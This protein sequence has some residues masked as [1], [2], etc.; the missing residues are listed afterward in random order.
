MIKT[1]LKAFLILLLIGG[2]LFSM[3][4][5][6][7]PHIATRIC[8]VGNIGQGKSVWRDWY[9][10]NIYRCTCWNPLGD[11]QYGKVIS[12][13]QYRKEIP[14]MRSGA[15]R[16]TVAPTTYDTE[17]MAE[18][19][20][21]LCA[22]V[23]EVGA[24]H[25]ATEEIA[26]VSTPNRVPPQF[27]RLCVTGRHRGVSMSTYGQRFH[28]FPLITRGTASEIIAFRQIDPDDVDDFEK[29]ILPYSSP[30]PVNQL[31]DHHFLHWTPERGVQYCEPLPLKTQ[32]A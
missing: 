19:F 20:D 9:L 25:I 18:E 6:C 15:L 17:A 22:C 30:I 24:Q 7:Q 11:F 10:G 8:V 32:A 21:E 27:S 31:P 3:S 2:A 13:K 14:K 29:R 12:V 4:E 23:W 5:I 16:V 1:N 28:Q 26:L